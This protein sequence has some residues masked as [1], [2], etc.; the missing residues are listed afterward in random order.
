MQ[1]FMMARKAGTVVLTGIERFDSTVTLPQFELAL[2]GKSLHSCQN[3]KVRMRRDIP[4]FVRML[5]DGVVDAK[6][7][8]SGVYPLAKINEALDAA[9]TRENLTGVIVP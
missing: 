6:P 1:A 4:R 7:I 5:E 3:G 8:I 2:R 9:E